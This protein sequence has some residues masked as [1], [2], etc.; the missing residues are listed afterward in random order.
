MIKGENKE[1]GELFPRI[2]NTKVYQ[3]LI[4]KIDRLRWFESNRDNIILDLSI[5]DSISYIMKEEINAIASDLYNC[6]EQKYSKSDKNEKYEI[7]Y[8]FKDY[9]YYRSHVVSDHQKYDSLYQIEEQR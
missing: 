2:T 8:Y 3:V 9:G 4:A 5:K 7:S 1:T 6:I